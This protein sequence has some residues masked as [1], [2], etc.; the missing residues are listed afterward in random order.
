MGLVQ[1]FVG[2]SIP[3]TDEIGLCSMGNA[4]SAALIPAMDRDRR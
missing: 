4:E 1:L 2:I 3:R